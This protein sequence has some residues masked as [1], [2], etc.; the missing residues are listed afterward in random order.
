MGRSFLRQ[1]RS[2]TFGCSK[3]LSRATRMLPRLPESWLQATGLSLSLGPNSVSAASGSCPI[4]S[5]NL[6]LGTKRLHS[7]AKTE[8]CSIPLPATRRRVVHRRAG[9]AEG[10]SG[11]ADETQRVLCSSRC[12]T[13]THQPREYTQVTPSFL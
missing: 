13:R 8:R 12:V 6:P 2:L 10:H 9:T 7:S 4:C 11:V 5:R 1:I 3:R